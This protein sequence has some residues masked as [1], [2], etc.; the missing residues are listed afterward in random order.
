MNAV[1][2]RKELFGGAASAVISRVGSFGAMVVSQAIVARVLSEE[3]FAAFGVFWVAGV[4]FSTIS[5]EG[6][7]LVFT[8]RVQ[9]YRNADDHN[10][11]AT[12]LRNSVKVLATFVGAEVAVSLLVL[13]LFRNAFPATIQRV[14]NFAGY[15]FVWSILLS[16]IAFAG[17]VA[18]ATGRNLYAA[19]L[20]G[21]NG[22]VAVNVPFLLLIATS[23]A[24]IDAKSSLNQVLQVLLALSVIVMVPST[25]W[26][27]NCCRKNHGEIAQ[28]GNSL[29]SY[30]GVLGEALPA[31]GVTL[32]SQ[33]NLTIDV[34][35]LAFFLPPAEIASIYVV[36]RLMTFVNAAMMLV[37][38][39]IRPYVARLYVKNELGSLRRLV[40]SG[41]Y[42]GVMASIA[43]L[44]LFLIFPAWT[45]GLFGQHYSVHAVYLQLAAIGGLVNVITGPC[46]VILQMA[47]RQRA[48]LIVTILVGIV[49]LATLSIGAYVWGGMGAMVAIMCNI[50]I[51]NLAS[52]LVGWYVL[53]FESSVYLSGEERTWLWNRARDSL[54]RIPAGL[55]KKGIG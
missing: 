3:D 20:S 18:R 50:I 7:S 22:N 4:L 51:S 43:P 27:M 6:V 46:S 47:G 14:M 48:L 26:L 24:M 49:N 52:W 2:R 39:T 34:I 5:S 16:L 55:R 30:R 53:G 44:C 10:H 19:I 45:M 41:T 29:T 9:Q 35:L 37:S 33:I 21:T 32:A 11:R 31:V 23:F 13:L 42:L 28:Q 17:E 1:A 15:L 40:K 12:L 8:R 54:G 38:L 25:L 36:R